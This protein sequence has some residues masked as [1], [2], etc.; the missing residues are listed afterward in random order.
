MKKFFVWLS[1]M[2]LFVFFIGTV[3]TMLYTQEEDEEEEGP[4]PIPVKPNPLAW[5]RLQ[6]MEILKNIRCQVLKKDKKKHALSV[7]MTNIK[8]AL[9][10][11]GVKEG[12]SIELKFP[13]GKAK[14]S[15]PS[16]IPGIIKLGQ[17]SPKFDG[18]Y[19]MPKRIEVIWDP[20]ENKP[21]PWCYPCNGMLIF[22]NLKGKVTSSIKVRV[23]VSWD[24]TE[25]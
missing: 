24:P 16:S 20:V 1:I 25:I 14:L 21:K 10:K 12:V 8:T 13:V 11:A 17:Y 9:E 5:E 23:F 4:D 22:K 3:G 15:G 2:I 18:N 7:P 6:K 19:F